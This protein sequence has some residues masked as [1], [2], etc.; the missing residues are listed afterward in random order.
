M[1][2]MIS[3]SLFL[4]IF[5]ISAQ[6]K[7]NKDKPLTEEESKELLKKIKKTPTEILEMFSEN[8][9]QCIDSLEIMNRDAELMSEGISKCI[10]KQV[11]SYQMFDKLNEVTLSEG[12]ASISI[13][14]NTKSGEYKSYYKKLEEGIMTYCPKSIKSA[15]V[16]NLIYKNSITENP[17]AAK[18]FDQGVNIMKEE[19]YAGALPYFKKAV[20]EDPNFAFAWDNLG[21]CYRR[22]GKVDKA[23]E[24]YQKSLEIEPNG[25]FPIQNLAVAYETIEKNDKAI[26]YYEKLDK[27]NPERYY[28]AG[29]NYIILGEVE[30]GLDQLC[31]AYNLY[32][33]QKS[34]YRTDAESIIA[35]VYRMMKEEG[36]E[37]KFLEILKKNNIN[38]N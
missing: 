14:M 17:K 34:P 7:N 35:E 30:K 15:I 18:L 31:K 8:T 6:E 32:V 19:N 10:D 24:A 13:N 20:K 33:D 25:S 16:D 21:L 23:I 22:T 28:G 1:K 3:F 29:R 26:E 4:V 27:L 11:M 36:K 37:E 2:A 12:D 9:C 5:L 38:T